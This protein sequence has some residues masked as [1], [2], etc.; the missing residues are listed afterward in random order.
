MGHRRIG[1]EAVALSMGLMLVMSLLGFLFSPLATPGDYMGVVLPC[2]DL[3]GISPWLSWGVNN[4]VLIAIAVGVIFLN[5]HYNFIKSPEPVVAAVFL[6]MAGSNIWVTSEF[7]ASTLL[8]AANFICLSYIFDT[9]RKSNATQEFFIVATIIAIGSMVQYSFLI[10][11]PVFIIAGFILQC[12][13]WREV[14]A[15]VLGLAAPY[16]IGLGFGLISPTDFSL[17]Q[18]TSIFEHPDAP[19]VLGVILLNIGLT[20]LTALIIGLNNEMKLYAGNSRIHALNSIIAIMGLASCI[21]IITDSSNMAAY[22]G[23]FYLAAA[24]QMANLYALN[25]IRRAPLLLTITAIIYAA[26]FTASIL[27]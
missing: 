25:K 21:G 8:L 24:F 15:F 23:T 9:Y 10:M 16:W 17:P 27:I 3:R 5:K 2:P 11:I 18:L 22:L 1:N 6:F 12:M 13:R 14:M 7:G 19:G 26:L 4:A 20:M